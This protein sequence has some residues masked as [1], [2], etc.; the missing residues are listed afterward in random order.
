ML[1]VEGEEVGEDDGLCVVGVDS[2]GWE[3]PTLLPCVFWG[4]EVALEA[5]ADTVE[6]AA[7]FEVAAMYVGVKYGNQL[8]LCPLLAGS[9][10]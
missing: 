10:T 2:V 8:T 5:T 4:L 1:R 6:D 7:A 3:V 9:E